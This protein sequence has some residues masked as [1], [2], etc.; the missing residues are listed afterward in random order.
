MIIPVLISQ[1]S[2]P[3][4]FRRNILKINVVPVIPAL[5]GQSQQWFGLEYQRFHNKRIS[6]SLILNLGI[7][8][9]YT[10]RKYNDY[11]NQH[12]GFSYTQR[13]VIT[14]GYHLIPSCK[15]YYLPSNLKQRLGL[16]V[17]GHIDFNQYFKNLNL[18]NSESNISEQYQFNT[19]RMGLGT[20]TGCQYIAF[21]RLTIEINLSFF[22]EVFES[23]S[24]NNWGTVPP[25]NAFWISDNNAFW[26]T[27]QFMI[28]YAF[29]GGKLK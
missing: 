11:F 2:I 22:I 27:V 14:K 21:T 29:G 19:S 23:S 12:E 15:Y 10:F 28:G 3:D 25:I 7:F 17:G 9:D 5:S 1:D 16:Y 26:S 6:F 24:N 8:E 4:N 13:D 18:I 20:S